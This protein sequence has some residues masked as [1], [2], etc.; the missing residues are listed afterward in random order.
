M[1]EN[2]SGTGNAPGPPASLPVLPMKTY[3]LVPLPVLAAVR[4]AA[5]LNG[6]RRG[7]P[8]Q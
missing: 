8:V 2:A 1:S 7:G 4:R 3:R 6:R 5:H